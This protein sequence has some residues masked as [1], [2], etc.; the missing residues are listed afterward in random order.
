VL[1]GI[2]GPEYQGGILDYCP[3][4]RWRESMSIIQEVPLL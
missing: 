2:T 3:Q 1:A 4:Q